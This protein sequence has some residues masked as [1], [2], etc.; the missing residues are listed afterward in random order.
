MNAQIRGFQLTV[1]AWRRD[2][3]LSQE[4]RDHSWD[5]LSAK[6]AEVHAASQAHI[7]L[8]LADA[9]KEA[10]QESRDKC[11]KLQAV[12]GYIRGKYHE[13]CDSVTLARKEIAAIQADIKRLELEAMKASLKVDKSETP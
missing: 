13:I 1:R 4:A 3:K 5:E 9:S 8:V 7:E 10:L 11:I 12:S 2:L 6:E